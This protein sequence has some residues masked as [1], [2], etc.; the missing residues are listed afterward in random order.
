[1]LWVVIDVSPE[2]QASFAL[3]LCVGAWAL[4]EV[5][6]YLF[7]VC[8]TIK[9]ARPAFDAPRALQWLRYNM[10]LV[11]YP[12]GISGEVG[13][14]LF[15]LPGAWR[16]RWALGAGNALNFAY[17][18]GVLLS[19]LLLLYPYGAPLMV[20]HMWRERSGWLAKQQKAA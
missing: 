20:G 9:Q 11:L 17:S 2:A 10:F 8:A 5:P 3:P 1:M 4:V 19:L 7:Y 14:L 12:A 6:R 13:C 18:H 16:L 15:A